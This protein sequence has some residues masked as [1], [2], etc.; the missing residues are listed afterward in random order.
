MDSKIDIRY[1]QKDGF[2][3][4]TTG[5]WLTETEALKMSDDIKKAIELIH[6]LNQVNF[7]KVGRIR[8][9]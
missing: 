6:K 5:T 1:D 2:G 3:I 7:D 8:E 4:S 9:D